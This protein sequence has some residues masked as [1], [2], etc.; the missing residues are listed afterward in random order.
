MAFSGLFGRGRRNPSHVRGCGVPGVQEFALP[1]EIR[2][3]AS[4]SVSNPTPG[5]VFDA[6]SS[7]LGEMLRLVAAATFFASVAGQAGQAECDAG[8]KC[9]FTTTYKGEGVAGS[10]SPRLAAWRV[11]SPQRPNR[12]APACVS[13]RRQGDHIRPAWLVQR[14]V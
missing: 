10:A 8:S 1:G 2:E 7:Y 11:A 9:T 4:W 6:A 14:G 3:H 13:P 5:R 12:P